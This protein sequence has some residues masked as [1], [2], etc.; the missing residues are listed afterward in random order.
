MVRRKNNDMAT[1]VRISPANIHRLCG[2][3]FAPR[4]GIGASPEKPCI[5]K[6]C[7]PSSASAPPRNN[8]ETPTVT[9]MM[10]S[11]EGFRI[12]WITRTWMA[13]PIKSRDDNGA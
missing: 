1:V 13:R 11:V 2:V 7:R 9:M 12:L 6:N 3:S 5:E 8:M 4:N 10:L